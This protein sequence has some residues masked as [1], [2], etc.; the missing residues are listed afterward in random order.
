MACW[1][2][3]LPGTALRGILERW[4]CGRATERWF[5]PQGWRDSRYWL[6]YGLATRY[7]M[8]W[9]RRAGIQVPTPEVVRLERAD[10]IARWAHDTARARG[11]CLLSAPVSSSVRVCRAAA[12]AGFDLTG[13]VFRAGGE[14]MTP[15]KA[16]I[17][18]RA[19][20]SY[21]PSYSMVEAH[22]IGRGCARPAHLGD[23][24]LIHDAYALITC[25]H[26]VGSSG[27]TVP[28]FNLTALL[29]R[30]PKVM[31]NV[32]SDDYGVIEER[33]CGCALERYGYTT[34]LRDIRSYSKLVGEGVTLIGN[35]MLRVL[36]S[37]LP[38]RFGGSALDYQLSEEEDD[39][40]L[41]RLFLCISP[42]VEIKDEQEVTAL[43]L[44]A[45][46][47]SSAM[48]D[49]ARAVWQQ[50]RS[51]RIRRAEPVWTDR[52]KLLPLRVQSR[53]PGS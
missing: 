39:A 25:P 26:P 50:A 15:A 2:S 44:R 36:E 9:M 49:A 7:M 11:G 28:A 46:S 40:G 27:L 16:D 33:S 31:L 53:R 22:A 1:R 20:A 29:D 24:H 34:H 48:A 42:R 14:P 17:I 18:A 6:R 32:Q 8:F 37:V 3:F 19:G 51:L 47:E 5:S 21:I 4:Y 12:D 13:V 10:V 30:A 45:L 23:L 35:E 43:V 41:T 52:G 38:A